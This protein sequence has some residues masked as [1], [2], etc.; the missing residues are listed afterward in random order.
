M[1]RARLR[2]MC[3]CSRRAD[4]HSQMYG[5]IGVCAL[6]VHMGADVL[7]SRLQPTVFDGVCIAIYMFLIFSRSHYTYSR[8]CHRV[9]HGNTHIDLM[10]RHPRETATAEDP[11][12]QR[13]IITYHCLHEQ[14]RWH[15]RAVGALDHVSG[16]PCSLR[17][18]AGAQLMPGSFRVADDNWSSKSTRTPHSQRSHHGGYWDDGRARNPQRKSPFQGCGSSRG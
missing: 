9:Q 17:T 16:A 5:C 6:P 15:T 13:Q 10:M 4:R 14:H 18:R 2:V 8:D 7:P 3:S 12:R 11:R 1:Q